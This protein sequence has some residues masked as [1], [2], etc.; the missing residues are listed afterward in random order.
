MSQG[1]PN[2]IVGSGGNPLETLTGNS[3]GPVNPDGAF[4]IDILG[5]NS[6]G[7]DIVGTPASNLL[8]A[9]GLQSSETQRGTVELATA[10]ETTSG[11]STSLA[12]HPS[13]LD[14]KL[15]TQAS[16]GIIYGQ[17]GAGSNLASLVE[18]TDGQLPIGDTG[19]PPVLSTLTA[20]SN[21]TINNG[22]GSIQ[23]NAT[24]SLAI[25]W[26][27]VVGTSA[28]L[29][30]N[31]GFVS[32]NAGLVTLTLPVAAA[33][34]DQFLIVGNGAGGWRVAQTA[35]QTIHILSS[36]TTTGA[37]GSLSSTNRYDAITLLCTVANTD[38]VVRDSMGNLTVV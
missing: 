16:N 17:G 30:V 12:V 29:V 7:I 37:G 1:G 32:N 33:F 10:A 8:T 14:T 19:G 22:S 35:G 9:I 15:G 6:S 25:P 20:G 11:V 34:G 24:G 27:D 18:G 23:I 21:I 4:N 3:G 31:E 26:N 28:T 38:F 13:G 5:N 36:D 2:S